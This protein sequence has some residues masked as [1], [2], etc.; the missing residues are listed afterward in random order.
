VVLVVGT[1]RANR[2]A[3]IP[4]AT[5]RTVALNSSPSLGRVT[6]DNGL[7][8]VWQEDHRQ[9]LVA[10]EARILGGLRGE[11]RYLG[12]G[13]THFLEHMLFKGTPTRAPGT[14]DQEVRR[15]GGSINAFTSHDSTGVTLF[16]DSTYLPNALELLA[17]IL[18][19]AIFPPEEFAKERAVVL[20]E[21]QM[22]RDDPERRLQQLFWGRHFLEHPYGQPILGHRS[23][24]EQLT[25][26]DL[27]SYYH[28]QYI[29]NNVV[30]ACAGDV[31]PAT[32]GD[33][34]RT[35]FGSWPRAT[36][37]QISA[38]Q[39][40]APA[41]PKTAVEEL[42]V[43]MSY[44][45]LG[46]PSIPLAHPDL[47]AL[48]VLASI[49][50]HGRTS[51]LYERLVRTRRLAQIA[52][53]ADY[54]PRDPGV[55]SIYL[56]T[57][58]DKASA[59]ID[60][61]LKVVEQLKSRG[62]STQELKKT[63]RQVE[64]EYIFGQQTVEAKA[65]RLANSLAL[66]G[67][68][69][70]EQH[71]VDGVRS[72]TA[73]QVRDVAR[74]YLDRAKMTTAIIQ[75]PTPT[76]APIVPTASSAPS[77][78][79]TVLPNGLT[80]LLG[81]SREL[82]M[83]TIVLVAR[84]GVR[85]E[86]DTTQGLSHLTAQLLLKGTTQ[87]TATDIATFVES[88]GGRLDAFSGRDGFGVSLELLSNDLPAGIALI[89]ELVADSTFP[90]QEFA[91]QRTLTLQELA[92]QDDDI[93]QVGTRQL[94]R[95]LFHGHPYRFDPLGTPETLAY[96]TRANCRAFAA[97]RLVPSNMVLAV[98][99]DLQPTTV[100]PL[101]QRIFGRM[102]NVP[103]PW[104]DHLEAEPLTTIVQATLPIPKEQS[105]ILLGFRGGTLRGPDRATLE[106]LTTAL[107][108]MS[109]RLFQV[110][111]EQHGLS[112]T[113][114]ASHTPGWDRGSLIIYAATKPEEQDRV[115]E[116]ILEELRHL[117]KT[118]LTEQEVEQAKRMLIGSNRL[119]LQQLGALTRRSA[120]D[121][122]LGEG[123]D[124]WTVYER[125]INAVTIPQL[126]AAIRTY[127]SPSAYAQVIVTPQ[128]NVSSS[129]MEAV[130]E[131]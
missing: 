110:V 113:L 94:R 54:T 70:Y 95:L 88:L 63:K 121:E 35:A 33:Q 29:P 55:F 26:D 13:I 34:I 100:R 44:V 41:S 21:I 92:A 122:Q 99:G 131:R 48:D 129:V 60:E 108:G 46:F 3:A 87:K 16:V 69:T 64:A 127:L 89:H 117:A 120:L 115:L 27:R 56:R 118:G 22:N 123:F 111:R 1:W 5:S 103:T 126:T 38:P 96:L 18:Q 39:E 53:A 47:Y 91:L 82:P 114:G 59:A 74:R 73:E 37:Y 31:N 45:V 125:Q 43:Q 61:A 128:T 65:G 66:T 83:A 85:A 62:V 106:V 90:Q 2:E 11:G 119:E 51:R 76:R 28:A 17:D 84:G 49:V 98:F 15:Y 104:P 40:P 4:T 107:S 19:H 102:R 50:G 124:A 12:T 20:S 130:H 75:P 109:G 80:V 25:V 68:P 79:K 6:L 105:V 42:P 101:V 52:E 116:T 86:T 7:V 112:Y 78:T 71:Y 23:L 8:A 67:D 36:P 77:V 32:I 10:I 97:Q 57:E 9:P 93:F 72:V 14:I 24:L 81:V 30:L 58:P